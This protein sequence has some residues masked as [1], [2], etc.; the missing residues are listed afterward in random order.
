MANLFIA[1]TRS[2]EGK[3]LVALGLVAELSRRVRGVGFMKPIGRASVEFAGDRIDHD[4]ALLKEACRIPAF[5]KDMGPV[6]VDGFPSD[7]TAP[8]G[9]EEVVGRIQTAYEK[10]GAGKNLLVIEGAGNAAAFAAVGL[11][12]AF[13]A[14]TLGAKAVLVATG[15]VGQPADEILLNKAYLDRSGIPLAGVILNKVYPE[16]LGRVDQWLRRVLDHL[17]TPLL[18]AIPYEHDLARATLINLFERFKGKVL[19][20]EAGMA[21]P[22]GKVV[23]GAMSAATALSEL[24]GQATLLCPADREDLLTA[25]MSAMFLSGRKDFALVS[26]VIAGSGTLSET[27]LR[28]IRRTS[29]PTLQVDPDIYTVVSEMHAGNFKILPGDTERISRA[30]ETVRRHVDIDLL[31]QSLNGSP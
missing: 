20:H 6:T 10:L 12:G 2:N 16:E 26:I 5:V 19:N 4:V 23:L 28:M 22:L 7:W 21:A 11:S 29:I 9:R 13:L 3:T 15:G 27:A 18:G 31:L 14:K 30:V 1:S 24:S 25:A 8:S 17:K